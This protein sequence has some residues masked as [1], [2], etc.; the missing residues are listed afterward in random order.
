MFQG[1]EGYST[2]QALV[3]AGLIVP[4]D[5]MMKAYGWDTRFGSS[6]TLD[7]LRWSNDGSTWG[8]GTL[9]GVAQKAEVLGA[10]YNK[11]TLQ[12]LGL[13]VPKTMDEFEHSLAVAKAAKCP[14]SRSET[15]TAGRWGT[16][17]WC[18]RPATRTEGDRR[19]DLRRPGATFDTPGTRKAAAV[20]ADWAKKGTSRT[21][22]TA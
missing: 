19:L 22:S 13:N 21:D 12:R 6:A 18:F 7:P 14:R 3:K 9:W 4:L 11:A 16:C 17:S 20:L 8:S 2:D 1:N 15:S 5:S 10:F